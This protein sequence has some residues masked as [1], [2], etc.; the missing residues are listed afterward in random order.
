MKVIQV[1]GGPVYGTLG[2]HEYVVRRLSEELSKRG[3][4]VKV[5]CPTLNK[6]PIR[7]RVHGIEYV[8]IPSYRL[9]PR[10]CFPNPFFLPKIV[11]NLKNA[12]LVHAHCPNNPFVFFMAL[13]SAFLHK[14]LMIT[15]LAYADDFK[16]HEKIVRMLGIFTAILQTIAI[17]ISDKVHVENLYDANKL[18]AYQNKI[19]IIPP[20]VENDILTGTSSPKTIQVVKDK[21]K[22]RKG[23]KIVLYLGRTHKAKGVNHAISA[24][25]MLTEAGYRPKLVIAGPSNSFFERTINLTTDSKSLNRF[26]YIGKVTDEEKIALIDLAD[27]VLIPSLS[28]VVEAY[29]LVAS[30]AWAR[31]KPV[32]AYAVGA[33]KYRVQNGINGYLARAMNQKELAKRIAVA[34]SRSMDFRIPWDVWSWDRV[35]NM[36]KQ[37]Y[38]SLLKSSRNVGDENG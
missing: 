15:V 32:V 27:I 14:P 10:L 30:E 16:H 33:L 13:L 25:A 24:V 4:E 3:S 12:D 29:S 26:I 22:S 36:C 38:V 2:G 31:R 18:H 35:A 34:L 21:I 11:K 28:D 19:L 17:W 23:E 37:T 6:S 5:L 1:Y 7:R 20:G 8:E 9:V